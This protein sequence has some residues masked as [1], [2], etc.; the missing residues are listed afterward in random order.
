MQVCFLELQI[1]DEEGNPIYKSPDAAEL[2]DAY[3]KISEPT[4]LDED[5]ILYCEQIPGGHVY[6]QN[7]ISAL[8]ETNRKLEEVH[9]LLEEE[10]ELIRLENELKEK[11]VA[12]EQRTAL[13]DLIKE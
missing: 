1:T 6:W 4:K 11:Q 5:T 10:S 7:D 9:D 3:R 2:N 13:Y 12:I 8:N